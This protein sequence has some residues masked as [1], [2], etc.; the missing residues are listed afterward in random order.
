MG[1]LWSSPKTAALFRCCER[2]SHPG[3]LPVLS[4]EGSDFDWLMLDWRL[5]L[6]NMIFGILAYAMGGGLWLAF[7]RFSALYESGRR[8]RH[9]ILDV[10]MGVLLVADLSMLYVTIELPVFINTNI[11]D[12]VSL[13]ALSAALFIS[14]VIVELKNQPQNYTVR[15]RNVKYGLQSMSGGI[16]FLLLL[17]S[18]RPFAYNVDQSLQ[19]GFAQVFSVL[20]LS[21]LLVCSSAMLWRGGR[22]IVWA[23]KNS[24]DLRPG[25][26]DM[27]SLRKSVRS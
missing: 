4:V 15:K 11:I 27:K 1:H 14:A 20:L 18:V 12:T 26:K 3:I 6:L 21:M 23:A 24:G 5:S 17:S 13:W 9:F 8:F 7:R 2:D 10:L 19:G 22:Y 16:I 25:S